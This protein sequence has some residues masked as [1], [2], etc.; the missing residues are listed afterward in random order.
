MFAK[1]IT[2]LKFVILANK[3]AKL[4]FI[5]MNDILDEILDERQNIYEPYRIQF[6]HLPA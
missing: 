6:D 1:M 5:W 4:T 2:C 3:S